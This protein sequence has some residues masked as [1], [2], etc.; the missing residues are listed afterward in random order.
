M[1]SL[2]AAEPLT[3]DTPCIH[4]GYNLRGL[5]AGGQCPECGHAIA[6]SLRGDLLRFANPDW[7]RKVRL[8][9]TVQLVGIVISLV[10]ISATTALA[11]G[12]VIDPLYIEY[13][14][15]PKFILLTLAAFIYTTREPR[16]FL[17][18][19]GRSVVIVIRLAAGFLITAHVVSQLYQWVL[20]DILWWGAVLRGL[21][22]AFVYIYSMNLFRSLAIRVP[23][24][25]VMRWSKVYIWSAIS[26]FTLNIFLSLIAF[27]FMDHPGEFLTPTYLHTK[28][29]SLF[30]VIASIAASAGNI[31]TVLLT[32]MYA[33]LLWRYRRML[34]RQIT[35]ASGCG[36]QVTG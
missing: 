14:F 1:E 29:P 8:G 33:W 25:S 30:W 22:M 2:S 11:V 3:R 21:A 6:E 4:C 20:Y 9:I 10:M 32:L 35:L 24:A 36:G 23:D 12:G 27:I 19:E 28:T 17:R 15:W 31:A 16:S 34:G 7:L 13:A 18:Q 26:V 5:A